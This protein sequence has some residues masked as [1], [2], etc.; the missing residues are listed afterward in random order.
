MYGTVYVSLRYQRLEPQIGVSQC[1]C[2]VFVTAFDFNQNCNVYTNFNN[3]SEI[4]K[5]CE[6]PSNSSRAER[7]TDSAKLMQ[8]TPK[9]NTHFTF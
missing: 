6:N 8:P 7:L 1:S 5:F 2:K 3:T 4:I 9:K